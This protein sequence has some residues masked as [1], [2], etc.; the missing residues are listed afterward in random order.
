MSYIDSTVTTYIDK[1]MSGDDPALVRI[2][3]YGI[4]HHIPI[5]G[6]DVAQFLKVQLM[7]LKP[8]KILEIGTAIGYSGGLMLSACDAHLTTIELS[9]DMYALAKTHFALLGLTDR[10]SQH[11][12]DASVVLEQL[13][14]QGHRYDTVFI[15]A[16]KGHY[17]DYFTKADT[18]LDI[19]GILIADNVLFNG[20]TCGLPHIRRQ[21]TIVQRMNVFI[22]TV[23]Q[24]PAYQSSLMPI[25]DGVMMCYK[26]GLHE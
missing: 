2:R 20:Y 22:D 14:Q 6:N 26:K 4:E 19:G 23:I 18:M 24:H 13:I 11:L 7:A 3:R 9:E 5:V 12:G 21:R 25:G 16:A 17:L 15:D 8:K 10:V 1:K